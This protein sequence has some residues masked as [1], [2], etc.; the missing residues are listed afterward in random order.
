MKAIVW[1]LPQ[2]RKKILTSATEPNRIPEF[3]GLR[4]PFT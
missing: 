2:L 4:D 1:E 3:L